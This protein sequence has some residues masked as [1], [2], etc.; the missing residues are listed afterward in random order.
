M[1]A[2]ILKSSFGLDFIQR[3]LKTTGVVLLVTFACGAYYFGF[4]DALAYFSAGIWSMVNL[5]FLSALVR[6]ALKPEGVDKVATAVLALIKFP[7]L[8]G[9]GY[10]L[11]TVEIFRPIPLV[12]GLSLVI[13]I[14]FL[15]AASRVLLNLDVVNQED[16][17][18]GLA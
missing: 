5:I 4:Y 14:M 17:T 2:K 7:L 10:F 8:Y 6:T 18:R 9:A 3:T 16:S 12:I 11:L 15:K 13:L 1:T